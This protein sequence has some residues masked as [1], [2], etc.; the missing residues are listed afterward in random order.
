MID[1]ELLRINVVKIRHHC[2]AKCSTLHVQNNYRS[3][4]NLHNGNFLRE[5]E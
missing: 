5:L 1:K 3:S 2:D 4:K